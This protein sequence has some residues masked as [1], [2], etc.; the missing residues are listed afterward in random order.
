[1]RKYTFF[2]L[3]F[4]IMLIILS[5]C[6][7]SNDEKII[8]TWIDNVFAEVTYEF[9]ENGDFTAFSAGEEISGTYKADGKKLVLKANN[10]EQTFEYAYIETDQR[11]EELTLTDA[12][13]IPVPFVRLDSDEEAIIAESESDENE[14]VEEAIE[15]VVDPI[16]LNK[17]NEVLYETDG[18]KVTLI[19][20][21]MNEEV[22]D[23]DME[24][25]SIVALEFSGDL[26]GTKDHTEIHLNGIFTGGTQKAFSTKPTVTYMDKKNEILI[27]KKGLDEVGS[28]KEL[29]RLDVSF[30]KPR[31]QQYTIDKAEVK[32]VVLEETKGKITVG[33]IEKPQ[34]AYNLSPKLKLKDDQKEVVISD[35]S[36]DGS[37]VKVSGEVTYLKEDV[38]LSRELA[39]LHMLDT[40]V[41]NVSEAKGKYFMGIPSEFT[42]TFS[43]VLESGGQTAELYIHGLGTVIDLTDGKVKAPKEVKLVHFPM[44]RDTKLYA[45][46]KPGIEGVLDQSG[47]RYYGNTRLINPNWYSP[48]GDDPYYNENVTLPLGGLYKTFTAELGFVEGAIDMENAAKGTNDEVIVEFYEA[49]GTH[50]VKTDLGEPIHTVV[51]P[52]GTAAQKVTVDVSGLDGLHI[53]LKTP[54][55]GYTFS[56]T[57]FLDKYELIIHNGTLT[58]KSRYK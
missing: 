21:G 11:G 13:G 24:T 57:D 20:E 2:G 50:F 52:K 28:D 56:E 22:I 48:D 3:I 9:K 54:R 47:K 37:S 8:G 55:G 39:V 23:G 26:V 31:A 12:E 40:H 51:L 1:M 14:E 42:Y 44:I 33:G 27:Y 45:E 53:W 49:T 41:K 29:L 16:E 35:I 38:E 43:K 10:T 36:I 18:G 15:Y 6:N 7:S 46:N 5:A 25:V 17:R 34:Y 4:G 30:T 58:H 32:S 19:G